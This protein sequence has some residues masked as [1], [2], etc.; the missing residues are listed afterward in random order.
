MI[1]IN[2]I[3]QDPEKVKENI[4]KKFKT[5]KIKLVDEIKKKDEDWN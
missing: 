2:I 5:D 4:K 3:R 1:D